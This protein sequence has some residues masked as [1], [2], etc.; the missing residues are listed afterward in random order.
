[1]ALLS[2]TLLLRWV[3]WS[4]PTLTSAQQTTLFA[5]V[6]FPSVAAEKHL[7]GKSRVN[8]EGTPCAFFLSRLAAPLVLSAL[9]VLQCLQIAVLAFTVVSVNE[10]SQ[11]KRS[12]HGKTRSLVI[13]NFRQGNWD[14]NWWSDFLRLHSESVPLLGLEWGPP[15]SYLGKRTKKLLSTC[16]FYFQNTKITLKNISPGCESCVYIFGKSRKKYMRKKTKGL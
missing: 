12:H 14:L 11:C 9:I 13:I 6:L 16:C 5:W 15:D 4:S 3:T 10:L 8:V 7:Q 2:G 1:M